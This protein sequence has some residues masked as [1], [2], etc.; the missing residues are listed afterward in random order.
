MKYL[1]L[2]VAL[3]ALATAQMSAYPNGDTMDFD[4]DLNPGMPVGFALKGKVDPRDEINNKLTAF[5]KL[6][7]VY[8]PVIETMGTEGANL[9]WDRTIDITILGWGIQL[10]I[11][12]EFVIGWRVSITDEIA[13]NLWNITY[14]PFAH[15]YF[16]T[17]VSGVTPMIRGSYYS[18]FDFVDA[19][20]PIAVEI[21]DTQVCLDMDYRLY[22]ITLRTH[23]DIELRECQQ[24]ILDMLTH[25]N[26][27]Y[28][29]CEYGHRLDADHFDITFVEYISGNLGSEICFNH[30]F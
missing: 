6:A 14:D 29:D 27:F 3:V 2:L 4:M 16:N 20:A 8:I 22:P 26:V 12:F 24:E 5:L 15:G 11:D 17:S 13:G 1:I 9:K 19:H 25:G 28:W 10:Y 21:F 7:E 18:E 23:M 30:P